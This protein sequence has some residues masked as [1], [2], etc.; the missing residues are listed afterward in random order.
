MK[1]LADSQ[2]FFKALGYCYYDR[3]TR[4]AADR[5]AKIMNNI[6]SF[7]NIWIYIVGVE[8]IMDDQN[9]REDRMYILITFAAFL[10][11]SGAHVTLSCSK[12]TLYDFFYRFEAVINQRKILFHLFQ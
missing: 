3:D 6:F 11:I 4:I 5:Q 1:F 8:F 9:S 2:K 7:L 12:L 10:G